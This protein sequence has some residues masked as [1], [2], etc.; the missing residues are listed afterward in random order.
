VRKGIEKLNTGLKAKAQARLDGFFKVLPKSEEE[1]DKKKR[2]K[3]RS[4]S[5]QQVN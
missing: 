5:F 4:P 1:V 2:K 3:V